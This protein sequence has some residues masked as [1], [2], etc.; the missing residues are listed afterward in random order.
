MCAANAAGFRTPLRASCLFNRLK[1]ILATSYRR[2][3]FP[4]VRRGRDRNARVRCAHRCAHLF[5]RANA[6]RHCAWLAN[7]CGPRRP[8]IT[9]TSGHRVP[10]LYARC[11]AYMVVTTAQSPMSTLYGRPTP[12]EPPSANDWW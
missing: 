1:P 12:Y 3:L 7:L 4:P 6:Q 2:P 10:A 11:T 9:S 8:G 5:F